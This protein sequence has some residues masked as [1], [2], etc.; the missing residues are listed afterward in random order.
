MSETALDRARRSARQTGGSAS[1]QAAAHEAPSL[2]FT[3]PAQSRWP[4]QPDQLAFHGF[5][6]ELVQAIEPHTEADPVALLAQFMVLFGNAVGRGPHTFIEASRHGLNEFAV[7]VGDSAN[8]RKGTS[9]NHIRR[10][11]EQPAP[12]W[13]ADRIMGGLSSG[14]GLIYN[15]RDAGPPSADPKK[16]SD[17]GVEDK[18]LLVVESEFANVLRV[19]NRQTNTISAV[20][21]NA[22]DGITLRTMTRNNAL[23]ATDTHVSI[24]GHITPEELRRELNDISILNGFANRFL[25]IAA[26]RSKIK[27]FGGRLPDG[28]LDRLQRAV[29]NALDHAR[30]LDRLD[31]DQA[32]REL[33]ESVYGKLT[34][35]P[36]GAMGAI[37]N[38]AAPHVRR[39]AMIHAALNG[40]DSVS[41]E[42][43]A[44]ALALWQ[45]CADSA[46]YIFGD[47]T[48]NQLADDV[49]EYL[50]AAL[51]RGMSRTEITNALGRH[52]SASRLTEALTTLER[53][54]LA[55]REEIKDTGGRPA[56]RW[57]TVGGRATP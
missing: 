23:K 46:R 49:L 52:V 3:T 42:H 18:R 34:T 11:F 38:R 12:D 10:L 24:L 33:W 2:D 57:F 7:I 20:I 35:A 39:L 14:E 17:P 53:A 8:G 32:A 54:R 43:L 41:D 22:W 19:A 40:R 51:D 16:P 50:R 27:P 26:K 9:F 45:Y 13:T 5:A 37:Y 1:Q 25:F 29:G 47:S 48:G 15:V 36:P 44:A 30:H 28:D 4:A 6:G 31:L 21:R 56:E 55:H